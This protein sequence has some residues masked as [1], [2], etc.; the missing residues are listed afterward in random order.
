[1][2]KKLFSI[3]GMLLL[4]TACQPNNTAPTQD[5]A[6]TKDSDARPGMMQGQKKMDQNGRSNTRDQM[7]KKQPVKRKSC[8]PNCDTGCR[9]CGPCCS[10]N[11]EATLEDASQIVEEPEAQI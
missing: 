3:M 4:A 11:S 10:D 1:M 6:P 9:S 7:N 8:G 2:K 5:S